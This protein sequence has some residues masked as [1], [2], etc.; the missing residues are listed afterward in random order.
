[1]E[2]LTELVAE[3]DAQ[4]PVQLSPALAKL[5]QREKYLALE[6]NGRRFN[7]GVKYGMLMGQLALALN[8]GDRDEIL[9]RMVE[10]LADRYYGEA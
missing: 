9:A 6:V 4:Q 1:M 5:A 7:I 8:G 2:I 3:S 10:L